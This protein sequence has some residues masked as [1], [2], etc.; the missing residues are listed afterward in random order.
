M[1]YVGDVFVDD[2]GGLV[3]VVVEVVGCG[4]LCGFVVF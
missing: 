3:G 4:V 1:G 2:V